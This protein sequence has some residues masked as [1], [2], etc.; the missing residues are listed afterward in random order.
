MLFKISFYPLLAAIARKLKIVLVDSTK[1][2]YVFV[3]SSKTNEFITM[4]SAAIAGIVLDKVDSLCCKNQL[5]EINAMYTK[6]WVL[7][8]LSSIAVVLSIIHLHR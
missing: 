6:D 7:V 8:G 4:S 5:S 1:N 2:R 3:D